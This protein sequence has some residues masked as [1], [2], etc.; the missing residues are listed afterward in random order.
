MSLQILSS[1]AV[2]A[3]GGML[4]RCQHASTACGCDMIFSI[5][6]PSAYAVQGGAVSTTP[7]LYWLSGLTC[8]DENFCQ[9]AAAAFVEAE[10]HGLV[11]VVPDTSP[12]GPHVADDDESSYDLG[13]GAGFYINAT[14]EPW[15]A[16]YQMETY[17]QTELPALVQS[18]WNL[19]P[20]IK[21]VCGHSMGGHGALTLAFKHP[22][23]WASVSALAPICHPTASPWGVKAFENYLGS[24]EAGKQHD[25]TEL[26]LLGARVGADTADVHAYDDILIDEGTDDEF[27]QGGQ[28]LLP[29]FEAAAAQ[30]G[31]KLTVRRQPGFDHSYHFIAA[32][33]R[34]HVAFHARYLRQAA[35]KARAAAAASATTASTT[36]VGKPIQC[37][38]M[39]ARA[40]NQPLTAETITVD[41][42]GRGEVRVR[43]V[44]NALCH[45]DVY[46]LD[47][48]DP[49]GLF[50]C[51]LGHEAGCVVESVGEG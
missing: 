41:P 23:A 24:V 43:V 49:E 1:R 45:T 32:F 13:Q 4:H 46:T 11:V 35:G 17:I 14:Q 47:G 40:P 44:A 2:T 6:L 33:I 36:T 27:G 48:Q 7:A 21:S 37:T 20:H 30:V 12:R 3:A 29:D 51:I 16:N 28:L 26:L 10:A 22:T 25:A 31:Q 9:K 38:A 15:K 18:Q 42:P 34:D 50:P 8:T 39:V 19:M 5:F